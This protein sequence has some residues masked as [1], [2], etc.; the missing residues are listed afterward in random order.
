MQA[1]KVNRGSAAV[2]TVLCLVA[3]ATIL[4]PVCR[5]VLTGQLPPPEADEGTGAHIFQLSVAAA[6]PAAA[7]FLVSAEWERPGRVLRPLVVP[8][9]ALA[10]AFALL[11][12]YEHLG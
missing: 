4:V 3:L 10:V 2:L 6:I 5:I 1:R 12:H 9:I 8:V 11:Y 7:V